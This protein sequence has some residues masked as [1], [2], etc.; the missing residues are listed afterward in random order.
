MRPLRP[1]L[2]AAALALAMSVPAS[3]GVNTTVTIEDFSYW[4]P[5]KVANAIANP[6]GIEFDNQDGV[7]HSATANG[8]IFDTDTI[9]GGSSAIVLLYG[10][11][12]YPYFCTVHGA[13]QMSAKVSLRPTAN[14]TSIVAGQSVTLRV[15]ADGLKG[16]TFDVQRRRNGGEW[17]TIR[18]AISDP[19]PTMTF[20]RAGTYDLRS[21]IAFST[22]ASRY[23]PVRTVT[24]AAA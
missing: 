21:R 10:A 17:T 16:A 6:Y 20:R 4:P 22:T 15:G 13:A 9:G 1:L 14:D 2:C 7:P 19:T 3:A 23:S 8:G 12:S 24:V 5:N 11:G 18:T